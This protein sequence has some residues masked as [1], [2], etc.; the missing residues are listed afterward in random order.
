MVPQSSQTEVIKKIR[1]TGQVT[2][3]IE[4]PQ[5]LDMKKIVQTVCDEPETWSP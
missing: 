3:M 4:G 5:V 2:K 1:E